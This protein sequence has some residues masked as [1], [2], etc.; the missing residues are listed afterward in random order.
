MMNTESL[1]QMPFTEGFLVSIRSGKEERDEVR[2]WS[3]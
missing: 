1:Q 3:C 2:A